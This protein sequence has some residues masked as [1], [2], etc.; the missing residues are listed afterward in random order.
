[1]QLLQ[2]FATPHGLRRRPFGNA[3]R[4]C[5]VSAVSLG[6]VSGLLRLTDTIWRCCSSLRHHV[7]EIAGLLKPGG[8]RGA[9]CSSER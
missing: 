2:T 9:L 6:H 4:F 5:F 1:M 3:T 8:E 7:G